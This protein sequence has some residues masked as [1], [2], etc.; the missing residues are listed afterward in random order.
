MNLSQARGETTW[1]EAPPQTVDERLD[2]QLASELNRGERQKVYDATTKEAR[3]AMQFPR[4]ALAQSMARRIGW[5]V[6]GATP[7]TVM[8]FRVWCLSDEHCNL[9]TA[10]G[11]LRHWNERSEGRA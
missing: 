7:F 1:I 6:Q 10:R 2:A 8:G 11:V 4:K 5:A 3:H 9:L